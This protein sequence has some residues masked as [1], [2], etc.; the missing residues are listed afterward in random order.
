MKLREASPSDRQRFLGR[1]AAS[2]PTDFAFRSLTVLSFDNTGN[3]ICRTY[4][5]EMG[6]IDST[7]A[8]ISEERRREE[9]GCGI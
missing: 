3:R 7:D 4:M 5:R 2:L 6:W 8:P 9:F 1:A